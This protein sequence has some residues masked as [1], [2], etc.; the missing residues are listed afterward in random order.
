MRKDTSEETLCPNSSVIV[1]MTVCCS[2]PYSAISS[3]RGREH[4]SAGPP[5]KAHVVELMVLDELHCTV[6]LPLTAPATHSTV[7]GSGET[8]LLFGTQPMVYVH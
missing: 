8:R 2:V 3:S 7:R 1:I 5:S 6:T 4:D